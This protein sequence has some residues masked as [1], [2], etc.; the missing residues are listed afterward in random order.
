MP[1]WISM[2][3]WS[4]CPAPA[5]AD[6]RDAISRRSPQLRRSGLHSV[7]FLPDAGDCTAVMIAA[8]ADE[9]AA[10]RLAAS[11]LPETEVRVESM[12]FDDGQ[13]APVPARR[14][15]PPPRRGY[16]RR[17]LHAISRPVAVGGMLGEVET[18]DETDGAG[19]VDTV[20]EVDT[21]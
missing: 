21:G 14:V 15:V 5:P 3:N 16:R 13:P 17:L 11:I 8:C 4:G 10:E 9:R 18:V 12:L 19:E 6:I 20:S 1:T 2:L 7:V